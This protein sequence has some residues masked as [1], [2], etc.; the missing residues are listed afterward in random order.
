MREDVEAEFNRE[1][2]EPT[3]L[4]L[5]SDSDADKRLRSLRYWQRKLDDVNAFAAEESYRIDAWQERQA[6]I[7]QKRIDWNKDALQFYMQGTGE[8]TVDLPNGTLKMRKGRERVEVVLEETFIDWADKTGMHDTLVRFQRSPDKKAIGQY[9]RD[10][11]E[12]PPGVELRRADDS[13][14]VETK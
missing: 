2:Q 1:G 10:T 7:I 9:I 5:G 13:F 14:S 6:Q 4:H 12:E 8:K 3:P 11:G